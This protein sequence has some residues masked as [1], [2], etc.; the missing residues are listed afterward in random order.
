MQIYG[1]GFD[2]AAAANL[3]TFF[4]SP[5]GNVYSGIPAAASYSTYIVTPILAFG[6]NSTIEVTVTAFGGES[7]KALVAYTTNGLLIFYFYL[8]DRFS[9]YFCYLYTVP[10]VE[11]KPLDALIATSV[12]R[13]YIFGGNFGTNPTVV[14]RVFNGSVPNPN[15][16]N[17][18][19]CFVSTSKYT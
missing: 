10:F 6:D 4:L 9:S 14:L 17:W 8:R 7:N 19:A 2:T 18:G 11:R 16:A 12:P 5:S 13:I 3:I 15:T 1:S